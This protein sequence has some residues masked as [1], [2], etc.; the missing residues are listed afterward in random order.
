MMNRSKLPE[1]A[2]IIDLRVRNLAGANVY[3]LEKDEPNDALPTRKWNPIDSDADA[4]ELMVHLGMNVELSLSACSVS[5]SHGDICR[6]QFW[7]KA[8]KDNQEAKS[9][10]TR[11][12]ICEVAY[13]ISQMKGVTLWE[14][15][16]MNDK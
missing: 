4:F 15:N 3:C 7:T 10:A 11:L 14:L 8:G 13:I 1:I 16:S 6:W 9:S 5:V 2:K 12:A